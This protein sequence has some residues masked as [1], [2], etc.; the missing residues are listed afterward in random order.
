[1]ATLSGSPRQRY[2]DQVRTEIKEAA[3]AQIGSGGAA[4]LS[5]NAIA[6][7]LGVSGPALYKYYRSRDDL[8]TELII[9]GYDDTAAAVAR[10]AHDTADATPR[11]RLH[12]LAGAYRDWAVANPHRFLLLAGPPSP[13]YRAPAHTVEHARAVLGPFLAALTTAGPWPAAAAMQDQMRTW[14]RSTP[15][16]ATWVATYAPEA[17]PGLALA[18]VV[19]LWSRLHGVVSLEIEGAFS[20]MGHDPGT[21]LTIEID[22]LADTLG[23]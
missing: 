8:L 23:L 21:L 13:T 1:M 22:S 6:K 10:A 12:S 18:A 4:A 5:L 11:A 15:A 14:A 20:G 19:T 2:R 7:T 3:L 9:D 17:E 16:V